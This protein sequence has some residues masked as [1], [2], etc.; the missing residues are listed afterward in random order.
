LGHLL[1]VPIQVTRE[2]GSNAIRTAQDAEQLE[3][4]AAVTAALGYTP[5]PLA[6][7]K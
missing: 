5:A 6:P 1:Q 2:T 3:W 7:N 4:T